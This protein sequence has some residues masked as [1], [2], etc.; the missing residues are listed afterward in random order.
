MTN[1]KSL[2]E[3]YGSQEAIS[4]HYREMQQK[5]MLNPSRQK[6]QHRGGFNKGTAE[7]RKERARKAAEIRWQSK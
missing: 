7:E 3:K 4:A 6:G 1:K 5:S 2:I